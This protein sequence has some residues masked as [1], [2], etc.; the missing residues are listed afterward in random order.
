MQKASPRSNGKAAL[1]GLKYCFRDAYRTRGKK[2]TA[3][4]VPGCAE[5]QSRRASQNKYPTF[6]NICYV[7]QPHLQSLCQR[8]RNTPWRW[9]RQIQKT[10]LVY[11]SLI[12]GLMWQTDHVG[13][14]WRK[15]GFSFIYSYDIRA[16][17]CCI[18][19]TFSAF[20]LEGCVL[21]FFNLKSTNKHC[22]WM[23]PSVQQTTY[24]D[25]KITG[26]VFL[27]NSWHQLTKTYFF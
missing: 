16:R 1:Q 26:C 23:R 25:A 20:L 12:C 4:Q 15:R 8:L 13:L 9:E 3:V 14:C 24:A 22:H 21:R 11:Q 18:I 17:S 7:R 5:F 10:Q 19:V 6:W 27:L 2:N